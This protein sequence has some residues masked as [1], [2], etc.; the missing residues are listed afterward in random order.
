M[1]LHQWSYNSFHFNLGC[2]NMR[3]VR[4]APRSYKEPIVLTWFRCTFNSPQNHQLHVICFALYRG[5]S[6][7]RPSYWHQPG[8]EPLCALTLGQVADIAAERWGDREALKSLYQGHRFTFR[9]LRDE[10]IEN[11]KGNNDFLAQLPHALLSLQVVLS[12]CGTQNVLH[13][14]GKWRTL[15]N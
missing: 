1:S 6:R 10:V 8:T 7:Y 2:I 5:S 9:E 4:L 14:C 13:I 15:S 12:R 11:W 3:L